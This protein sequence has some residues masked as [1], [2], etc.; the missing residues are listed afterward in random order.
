MGEFLGRKSAIGNRKSAIPMKLCPY[1]GYANNDNATQCRKCDGPFVSRPPTTL[2]RKSYWIGP[3]KARRIRDK[4]LT[5]VVLGLLIKVYWGGYGPW[6]VIDYAPFAQLR[7]WLEP[8]LLYGGGL[9]Y[10]VGCVLSRV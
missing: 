9:G 4:A 3:G 7:L 5:A 1:C 8:L 2:S 10:V 6:P